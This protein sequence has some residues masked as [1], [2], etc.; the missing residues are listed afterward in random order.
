M[1]TR[2][3][4]ETPGTERPEA[5]AAEAPGKQSG[6]FA[7]ALERVR[8]RG[9]QGDAQGRP[10]DPGAP[11]GK[12][13]PS[14]PRAGEDAGIG[15]APFRVAPSVLQPPPPVVRPVVDRSALVEAAQAIADRIVGAVR[16]EAAPTGR[17][18]LVLELRP[19]VLGGMEIRVRV[20]AGRV[21]A[22]LAVQ[23][24]EVRAALEAQVVVLRQALADR[25]LRVG[26][27]VV[28][29]ARRPHGGDAGDGRGG[30]QGG[31]GAQGGSRGR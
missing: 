5:P 27:V 11:T 14:A 3:V 22:V 21:H 10:R 25:G 18:E 2:G 28:A 12:D 4:G 8:K 31:E 20:E 1:K 13:R 7:D 24:P 15:L 9:A 17:L 26:E 23:Q 29:D 30:G 6:S 19:E 16:L